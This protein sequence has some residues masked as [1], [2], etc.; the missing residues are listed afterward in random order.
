[1]GTMVK[2]RMKRDIIV[3]RGKNMKENESR[4]SQGIGNDTHAG[5]IETRG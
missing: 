5:K 2:R 1:M 4:I 3:E